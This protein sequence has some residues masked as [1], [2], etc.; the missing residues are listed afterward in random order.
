M[1]FDPSK[2]FE[3]VGFDPSKPFEDVQEGPSKLEAG[4]RGIASGATLGFEDEIVGALKAAGAK[5]TGDE[6]FTDLYRKYRDMERRNNLL[7]KEA[8]PWIYGAGEVAGGIGSLAIPGVGAIG[9]AGKGVASAALGGAKIGAI[10]GLGTSEADITRGN[11]A[12]AIEDVGKGTA[13]GGV[14]GAGAGLVGKALQKKTAEKLAEKSIGAGEEISE[15]QA[16]REGQETIGQTLLERQ[17]PL[18]GS[19]QKMVTKIDEA[20]EQL[21]NELEDILQKSKEQIDKTQKVPLELSERF[22]SPTKQEGLALTTSKEI[23]PEVVGQQTK[24]QLPLPIPGKVKQPELPLFGET[25]KLQPPKY[26]AATT[27]AIETAAET[28]PMVQEQLGLPLLTSGKVKLPGV[29]SISDD[30]SAALGKATAA[31]ENSKGP[32]AAKKF[33]AQQSDYLKFLSQNEND[34]VKLQNIKRDLYNRTKD[35]EWYQSSTPE[36]QFIKDVS[37]AVKNRIEKLADT[38]DPG[39]GGKI[40][41]INR[42]IGNLLEAK[43]S[44]AESAP[45]DFSLADAKLGAAHIAGAKA[46]APAFIAKKGIEYLTKRKVGEVGAGMAA[47]G[48]E[49]LQPAAKTITTAAKVSTPGATVHF[50]TPSPEHMYQLSK[51]TSDPHL[52]RV[53]EEGAK[54]DDTGRNALIFS[55]SQYPEYREQL[56]PMGIAPTKKEEEQ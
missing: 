56:K 8:H 54:K 29:T 9:A 49:K 22:L 50:T 21:Y 45:K 26:G 55:L 20:S 25:S 52:A 14:L 4:L 17:I 40:K 5:I 37:I 32:E 31:I 19:K 38:L 10:T 7:S 3:E 41:E 2:P 11:V 51:Q 53:L 35:A 48:I 47:K 43:S 6:P 28:A 15:R 34:I 27:E 16:A 13:I 30:A 23:L 12:G 39:V 24:G 18:S 1:A 33:V 44:L 46:A 36:K 42:K